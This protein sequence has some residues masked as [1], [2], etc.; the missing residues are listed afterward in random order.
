MLS[1]KTAYC[2]EKCGDSECYRDIA[3]AD[4]LEAFFTCP[5]LAKKHKLGA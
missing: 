2:T 5:A 1:K 3:T 4:K